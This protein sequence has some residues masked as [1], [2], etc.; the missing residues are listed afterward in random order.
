MPALTALVVCAEAESAQAQHNTTPQL[1]SRNFM[2]VHPWFKCGAATLTCLHSDVFASVV[3]SPGGCRRRAGIRPGA[4]MSLGHL[5][6]PV[7]VRHVPGCGRCPLV[8]GVPVGGVEA[9][10]LV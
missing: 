10:D 6:G 2:A 3:G 7:G 1:T 9:R 8:A 5:S 4:R